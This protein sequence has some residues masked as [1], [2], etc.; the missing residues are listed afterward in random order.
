MVF[1][2]VADCLAESATSVICM[3][4]PVEMGFLLSKN[5]SKSSGFAFFVISKLLFQMIPT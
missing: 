2:D 5:S 1:P 4:S 3:I